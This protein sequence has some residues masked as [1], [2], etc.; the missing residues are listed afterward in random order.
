MQEGEPDA[1]GRRRPMPIE[2]SEFTIQADTVIPSVSQAPSLAFLGDRH[3]F[4]ISE[5]GAFV[6]DEETLA[7]NQP[8]IF[9]GGDAATGPRTSIEAIASAYAP[10]RKGH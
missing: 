3:G 4:E 6:V 10:A 1:S 7:T 5:R 9:A 8:G 2:G